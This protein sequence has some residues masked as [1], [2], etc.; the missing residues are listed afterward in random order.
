MFCVLQEN[1][2]EAFMTL[3]SLGLG[4]LETKFIPL[5]G[6]QHYLV[7]SETMKHEFVSR[8]NRNCRVCSFGRERRD[9]LKIFIV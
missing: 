1:I 5:L 9:L 6:T 7:I 2:L 4:P 8:R 3:E